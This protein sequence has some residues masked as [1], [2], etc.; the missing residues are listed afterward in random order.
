[1]RDCRSEQRPAIYRAQQRWN[2]ERDS[3]Y[4][5]LRSHADPNKCA[6]L[7]YSTANGTRLRLD[8]CGTSYYQQ[9]FA[10]PNG[11]LSS[12]QISS[13]CLDVSG[14]NDYQ[15]T[16]GIGL[17]TEGAPVGIFDCSTPT[18]NQK[19]NFT[20]QIRDTLRNLCVDREWNG[21]GNGTQVWMWPCEDPSTLALPHAQKWD[22]YF[23]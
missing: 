7:W 20:G 19:W 6:T 9:F 14:P 12:R 4:F 8:P 1:M 13:R 5:R 11:S 16:H 10:T 22:Y 3:S 15:Y 2:I 23:K 21:D 17:P 18:L